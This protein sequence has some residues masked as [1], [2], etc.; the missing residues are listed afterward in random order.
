LEMALEDIGSREG[1]AAQAAGIR[2]VA[3]I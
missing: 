3:G 1:V 2:A